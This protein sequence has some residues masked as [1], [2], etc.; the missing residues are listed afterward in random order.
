MANP[1]LIILTGAG[2]SAESGLATFRGHGGLWAGHK[3]EDVATPQAFA[4][5]PEMVHGFYNAR[6]AQLRDPAVQ[7]NPAHH[8]LA[9]LVAAWPAPA[10]LVTQNV[11]DLHHRAMPDQLDRLLPMHGS[12][13]RIRCTRCS[14]VADWED[15]LA[16]DTP[17]PGCGNTGGL[18]P[19]IVWF[20]EMPMGMDRIEAALEQCRL[21]L[22]IGTSGLVYPA[23]GFVA[24]LSGVARTVELNLEPSA[25]SHL[26]DEAHHGPATEVV[27]RFVDALL[28]SL[29]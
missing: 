15:D 27:P 22:S 13:R 20:G 1:P 8:A 29:R 16:T 17:C 14:Q 24:A 7:P 9:R 10:L 23:A 3:V 18:R 19:D 4:R 6:R 11:D 25:G 5:D 28:A 12:L 26:F 21:F 2:I